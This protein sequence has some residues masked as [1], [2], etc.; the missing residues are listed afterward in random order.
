[1]TKLINTQLRAVGKPNFD[2]SQEFITWAKPKFFTDFAKLI[3]E[4]PK[5]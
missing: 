5:K 1:M 2:P 4:T 3:A